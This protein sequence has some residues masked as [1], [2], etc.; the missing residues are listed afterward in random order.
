MCQ[1]MNAS[2]IQLPTAL[3]DMLFHFLS[4]RDV[5]PIFDL[6]CA[7]PVKLHDIHPW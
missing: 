7:E 3:N 6:K 5:K 2:G 4:T 1:T